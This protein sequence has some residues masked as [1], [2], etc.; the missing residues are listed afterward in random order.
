MDKTLNNPDSIAMNATR[1][2]LI[3]VAKELYSDYAQ[4]YSNPKKEVEKALVDTAFE[5]WE[6][7][8]TRK[9][10]QRYMR[11]IVE[12]A[13]KETFEPSEV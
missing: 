2:E 7:K 3:E 4:A 1:K 5:C 8:A 12:E 9:E 11:A 10:C 6:V 13:L